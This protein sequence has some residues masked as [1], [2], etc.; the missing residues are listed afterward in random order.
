MQLFVAA[1]KVAVAWQHSNNRRRRNDCR[2]PSKTST[3]TEESCI[4]GN[5]N[6]IQI[7]LD[8]GCNNYIPHVSSS[9]DYILEGNNVSTPLLRTPF[10]QAVAFANSVVFLSNN[11]DDTVDIDMDIDEDEFA[12]HH[13]SQ[14]DNVGDINIDVSAAI[15]NSSERDYEECIKLESY[16]RQCTLPF[17]RFAALLK[18]YTNG[19]ENSDNLDDNHDPLTVLSTSQQQNNMNVEHKQ[20]QQLLQN[21]DQTQHGHHYHDNNAQSPPSVEPYYSGDDL[22]KISPPYRHHW[23]QDDYEFLTL[24]RY[25]KLLNSNNQKT[26]EHCDWCEENCEDYEMYENKD[27]CQHGAST[28]KQHTPPMQLPSAMDAVIWPEWSYSGADNVATTMSRAWLIA[29]RDSLTAPKPIIIGSDDNATGVASTSDNV[30][31]NTN[32]LAP[33]NILMS[34]RLL[35]AI[36]CCD[37]A[38]SII[39]NSM[40]HTGGSS[41]SAGFSA[42]DGFRSQLP[43]I[44]WMGPR[45]LKLPHLYD[46]VFQYYHGRPCLRCHGIPRETSVCLVCGTVVCLKENCCKTN[47]TNEAVQVCIHT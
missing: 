35:L 30:D 15:T 16:G 18:K 6:N 13:D 47:G 44:N 24:V 8:D 34:A 43:M 5:S 37:G 26:C 21:S 14:Q 40:H 36:D 4:G 39:N 45:L 2:R 3:E 31:A 28:I 7:D 9:I 25:L 41:D 10:L 11:D 17:L 38:I 23:S 22:T 46:D 27:E 32:T 1:L 29:F 33:T 19:D 20:D 42:V 12:M